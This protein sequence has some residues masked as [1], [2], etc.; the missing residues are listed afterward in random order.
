MFKIWCDRGV[1]Y[2]PLQHLYGLVCNTV[3]DREKVA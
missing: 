1:N 2:S 3:M